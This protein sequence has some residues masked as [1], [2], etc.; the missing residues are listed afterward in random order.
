MKKLSNTVSEL[1]KAMVIKKSVYKENNVRL[2]KPVE[3]IW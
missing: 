3:F 1:K 2:Q